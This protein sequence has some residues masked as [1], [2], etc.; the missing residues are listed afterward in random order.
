MSIRFAEEFNDNARCAVSGDE[1][2]ADIA[3]RLELLSPVG[4]VPKGGEQDQPLKQ[5]L[6]ELAG[7]AGHWAAIGKD[8]RPGNVGGP[9]P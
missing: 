4:Q 6:V 8:K 9:A 2:T 1:C 5:G 3:G 7:M